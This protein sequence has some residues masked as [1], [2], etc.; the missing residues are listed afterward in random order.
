MVECGRVGL[1]LQTEALCLGE[2]RKNCFVLFWS[3]LFCRQ[4]IFWFSEVGNVKQAFAE[5]VVVLGEVKLR[6][7]ARSTKVRT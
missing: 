1:F 4:G 6:Q 3:H 7:K 2:Q 5:A